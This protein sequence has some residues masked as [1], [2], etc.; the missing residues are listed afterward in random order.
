MYLSALSCLNVNTI[1]TE[2]GPIPSYYGEWEMGLNHRIVRQHISK[3]N[4]HMW[5]FLRLSFLLLDLTSSGTQ[6]QMNP[7][8]PTVAE[9]SFK[10]S[11]VLCENTL[12]A[13]AAALVISRLPHERAAWAQQL[14]ATWWLVNLGNIWLGSMLNSHAPYP[15]VPDPAVSA[16]LSLSV[17]LSEDYSLSSTASHKEPPPRSACKCL[18]LTLV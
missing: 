1:E 7:A 9:Q 15:A 12:R 16:H 13:L 4:K 5:N 2:V 10:K 17:R 3:R 18:A 8:C 6:E 14:T 11:G